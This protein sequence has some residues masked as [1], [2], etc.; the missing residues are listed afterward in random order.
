MT[1]LVCEEVNLYWSIVT[2][3]PDSI[4]GCIIDLPQ[5]S[6]QRLRIDGYVVDSLLLETCRL[7]PGIRTGG[8]STGS[9]LVKLGTE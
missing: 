1:N 6:G 7:T 2:A 3:L 9:I 8:S 4:R 5:R